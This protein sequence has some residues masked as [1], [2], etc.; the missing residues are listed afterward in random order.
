M[1]FHVTM[2]QGRADSFTLESN[3]LND[4]KTFLSNISTAVITSI[5]KIVFSKELNINYSSRSVVVEPYYHSVSVFCK[6]DNFADIITLYNVKKSIT[7]K[8]ILDNVKLLT[9]NNEPII[10]IYNISIVE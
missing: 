8:D 7:T 2:T 6:S 10:D 5:K 1:H 3:S 9:L 4:L